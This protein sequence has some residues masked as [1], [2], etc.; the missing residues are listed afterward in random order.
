MSHPPLNNRSA[1]LAASIALAV[2]C[3]SACPSAHAV[4]DP[5]KVQAEPLFQEGLSLHNG[6]R[7]AEALEKFQKA[8]A[9]YPSPNILY[10]VART[11][12]LT[13]RP[14]DA[15]R[16]YREALKNPTIHPK[17]DELARGFIKE[18]EGKEARVVV[19]GPAGTKVRIRGVEARLPMDG[20]ID[21]DP[22]DVRIAGERDAETYEAE[23]RALAGTTT[24]LALKPVASAAAAS[25][26]QLPFAGSGERTIEPPR[27]DG[28]TDLTPRNVTVIATGVAGVALG[29]VGFVFLGKTEDDKSEAESLRRDDP[30]YASL[31]NDF[32]SD[33]TVSTACLVAGVVL[34]AGAVVTYFVW[35]TRSQR[36]AFV[37][38]ALGPASAGI[39]GRF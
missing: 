32:E 20:P 33:Q 31:K 2:A 13:G 22:G 27:A 36:G 12:Q 9:I 21:V 30:R 35:P 38:P 16:H 10:Y 37:G 19:T 23:G 17:N 5:R 1:R 26:A 24:T 18:L 28:P 7:E 34:V 14:L 3:V 15:L 6:D 25:S 4:D 29:V 11:E 8:Y 39:W